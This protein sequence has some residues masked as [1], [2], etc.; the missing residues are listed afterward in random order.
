MCVGV[1]VC[2]SLFL[3]YTHTHISAGAVRSASGLASQIKNVIA[4]ASWPAVEWPQIDFTFSV[5]ISPLSLSS[6]LVSVSRSSVSAGLC[7]SVGSGPRVEWRWTELSGEVTEQVAQSHSLTKA[8]VALK[9][10]NHKSGLEEQSTVH[11]NWWHL[12]RTSSCDLFAVL[13]GWGC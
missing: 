6:A 11:A 3:T 4:A 13:S 5:F 7:L 10:E 9:K 1:C 2:S 12:Y 8:T